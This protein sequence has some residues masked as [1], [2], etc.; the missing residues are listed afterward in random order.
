MV[1]LQVCMKHVYKSESQQAYVCRYTGLHVY[2]SRRLLVSKPAG[3]QVCGG[4]R[5]AQC[6]ERLPPL[7]WP[8]FDSGPMSYVDRVC[9]WFSPCSEG[10]SPY[11]FPFPPHKPTTANS[12]STT[13]EDSHENQLRLMCVLSK[14]CNLLLLLSLPLPLLLPLPLS[15]SL[16]LSLSLLL[17]LILLLCQ[18]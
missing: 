17:L 16:S 7:M 1:S 9:C 14:Y 11:F 12:N 10:F 15:L 13:K 3:L 18:H 5:L 6:W 4:V 8:E 2:M